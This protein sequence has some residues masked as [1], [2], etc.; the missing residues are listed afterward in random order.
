[1]YMYQHHSIVAS[2]SPTYARYHSHHHTSRCLWLP[3]RCLQYSSR[4]IPRKYLPRGSA[5]KLIV[6]GS[7]SKEPLL[8][9]HFSLQYT[10]LHNE[11]MGS[12]LSSIHELK[13]LAP[14]FLLK[15]PASTF[16]ASLSRSHV[17]PPRTSRG[18][19]SYLP[20]C[21]ICDTGRDGLI[22]CISIAS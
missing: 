16:V 14:N 11:G 19:I 20:P 3:V 5:S 9:Q 8:H 18:C 22:H 17:F 10:C 7:V 1:M 2:K 12:V 15:H 13:I 4:V 6:R 21:I